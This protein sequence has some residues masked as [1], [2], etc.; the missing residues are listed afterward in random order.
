MGDVSL[1]DAATKR[2]V[3][4]ITDQ[5]IAVTSNDEVQ[6]PIQPLRQGTAAS[7]DNLLVG[8]VADLLEEI[9]TLVELIGEYKSSKAESQAFFNALFL[10]YPQLTKTSYQEAINIYLLDTARHHFSF[11]VSLPEIA[12]WWTTPAPTNK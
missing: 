4:E 9:K 1:S 3:I 11:E 8:S 2:R 5:D 10:R 12:S 7:A 6:E